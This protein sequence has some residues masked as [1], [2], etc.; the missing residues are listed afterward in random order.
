M[1]TGLKANECC[2]LMAE[3]IDFKINSILVKNVKNGHQRYVLRG[4]KR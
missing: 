1:D 4:I 2:S 3:D